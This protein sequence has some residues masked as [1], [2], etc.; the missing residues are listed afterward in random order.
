MK[1]NY[2][3]IGDLI[4]ECDDRNVSDKDL[5][6]WGVSIDKKF[7]K[8]VANIIGTD[9]SKYKV[10]N[11]DCFVC[12]LMQVSRDEKIPIARWDNDYSALVSP[13]YKVFRIT[14]SKVVLPEYMD[15][16]F[17]R[18]EFDREASFYGVGGVRGSLEW[19]DFCDM[20]LPIPEIDEQRRI[21]NAYNT[22]ESRIELKRKINENLESQLLSLFKANF[23]KDGFG[24]TGV[25]ND[26][27]TTTIGGD[28]GEASNSTKS[29]VRCIRGTD[30]PEINIG[31]F[32]HAPIRYIPDRNCKAKQLMANDLIIE[33]SG[34]SPVQSTGRIAVMTQR[35]LNKGREPFICSNFC[36]V[37][38]VKPPYVCYFLQLWKCLYSYGRMFCYE[39]SSTGLKNFDLDAF[40]KEESIF[41]PDENT[42]K[43]FN[44]IAF[45]IIIKQQ[46]N[47]DEIESLI[48][49][50][51]DILSVKLNQL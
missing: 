10:I 12:S 40:I 42:A 24:E 46:V 41:I 6:L 20:R 18:A 34:G 48:K 27:V 47:G 37:L 26:L 1:S 22:I 51:N 3:R 4:V 38:R 32:S 33:I 11:K 14:D 5:E 31:L 25:F 13:A 45:P 30:I 8:S 36:R 43:D 28:W 39:N 49:L 15:L 44:E 16:W 23:L 19:T 7:I 50:S 17:K 35:T 2:K 9:L 21:V 29:K